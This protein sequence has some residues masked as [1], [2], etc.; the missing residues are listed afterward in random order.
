MPQ[1]DD[2]DGLATPALK[3]AKVVFPQGVALSPGVAHGLE[4]CSDAQLA[5]TT[6][7]D[8]DCPRAAK[9]GTVTLTSPLLPEAIDGDIYI[10]QPLPG[11]RYRIFLVDQRS[12]RRDQA[13]RAR[14]RRIR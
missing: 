13:R 11:N 3:D 4:A 14:C 1:S 10:G 5:I 12:R 6:N 7:G 2:P 8:V 9:I